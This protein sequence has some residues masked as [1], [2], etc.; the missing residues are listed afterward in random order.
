MLS[1]SGALNP[2]QSAKECAGSA[3]PSTAVAARSTTGP[4]VS[5]GSTPTA[6][7]ITTRISTGTFMKRGGSCGVRGRP[8]GAPLKNTSWTNRAEYATPNAPPSVAA[9]GATA[10][11]T[12]R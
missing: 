1:A 8:R 7:Q 12:P 6:M 5:A 3:P 11:R 10:P 9:Y 4:T 2:C